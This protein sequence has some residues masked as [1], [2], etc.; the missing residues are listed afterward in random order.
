MEYTEIIYLVTKTST[1]DA[2][3]N[4]VSFD[5]T[6]K[7]IYAKKQSVKRGEFYNAI[8]VGITPSVEFVIKRANFNNEEEILWNNE[9][10]SIVRTIDPENKFDIVLVCSKKIGVK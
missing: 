6:S 3:G 7:K 1:E 5:T 10:Y 8:E 4:I 9:R 2:I